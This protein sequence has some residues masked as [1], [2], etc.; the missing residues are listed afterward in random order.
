M[1]TLQ[2]IKEME[3]EFLV[4]I[5]K[6]KLLLDE[7]DEVVGKL[8]LTRSN[9]LRP[10][11]KEKLESREA[12]LGISLERT[13]LRLL[14]L[15]GDIEASK[16]T[17][18]LDQTSNC[19]S[20]AKNLAPNPIFSYPIFNRTT[21]NIA[22]FLDKFEDLMQNNRVPKGNWCRQVVNCF[23]NEAYYFVKKQLATN[24][25]SWE[26]YSK[27]I[28]E[29]FGRRTSEVERYTNLLYFKQREGEHIEICAD[30][31][32]VLA[33]E[34]Q[35]KDNAFLVTVFLKGVDPFVRNR[36]LAS[37]LFE[38]HHP[39]LP[40]LGDVLE[41][42]SEYKLLTNRWEIERNFPQNSEDKFV[43]KTNDKLP[44]Y[45]K[46]NVVATVSTTTQSEEDDSTS[47]ENE[48]LD[49]PYSPP[50]SINAASDGFFVPININGTDTYALVDT[51]AKVS[52]VS[53]R[54][55]TQQRLQLLPIKGSTM[56]ADGKTQV[57][58]VITQLP[59]H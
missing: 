59:L 45:F 43:K 26:D 17:L 27:V 29:H 58:R 48:E 40:D 7:Q 14:E 37:N 28:R 44:T 21:G 11:E 33:S 31:F 39:I 52:I 23:E 36:L 49:S 54:L 55:T 15:K 5:K 25:Q 2:F 18:S 32:R 35:S 1:N 12:E 6:K 57:D 19:N 34:G 30:R 8:R 51:G 41:I 13:K 38:N 22:Y 53:R 56:M 9:S 20:P 50:T 46:K 16:I 24:D 47:E 10:E 3:D 42:A 4:L